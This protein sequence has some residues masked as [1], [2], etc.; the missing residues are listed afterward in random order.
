MVFPSVVEEIQTNELSQYNIFGD[1]ISYV[2][3]LHGN[4]TNRKKN[5]LTSTTHDNQSN[6]TE[7]E[8]CYFRILDGK[9][10]HLVLK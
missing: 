1:Y 9:R 7:F 3:I 4:T 5:K 8:L 10:P 2:C 6:R